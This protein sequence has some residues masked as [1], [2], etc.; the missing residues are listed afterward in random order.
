VSW[1]QLS[2]PTVVITPAPLSGNTATASITA[3][4][5]SVST[6]LQFQITV[7]DND[8]ATAT[9]TVNITVNPF[10]PS[11]AATSRTNA[12]TIN[13]PAVASATAYHLYYA[14]ESM[15]SPADTANYATFAG[16]TVV[17]NLTGTSTT[18]SGLTNGTTYYFALTAENSLGESAPSSEVFAA[19]GSLNDT[20]ISFGGDYPTGNNVGCTGETIAQQDCSQGRDAQA[21]ASTLSKVG[22]GEAGF[23][24]TK[25]DANGN[26]LAANAASWSCAQDNT[27]GLMW[28]VK[29]DDN[30]LHDKDDAYNWYNTNAVTN[31]GAVGFADDDGDICFAYNNA[32]SATYCNTEAFVNRVNTAGLCGANDWRVPDRE[33]L[34][35]IVNYSTFNP[36]IDSNYFSNTVSSFYWSSSPVASNSSYAWGV[37]FVNG[38]D[39]DLNRNNYLRV[40]LVRGGQ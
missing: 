16:G 26:P 33:A 21:A 38:Y 9:D 5:V 18:V 2:G 24:F 22:A 10:L 12:V 37:N 35:S 17:Q 11:I 32:D 39:D 27:T 25:L 7:T 29:T 6:A 15:G 28:E 3:P 36:A 8:G 20:G 14:E 40:R 30:G 1:T 34:R 4:N 31:G 13:W 19:P 23:D